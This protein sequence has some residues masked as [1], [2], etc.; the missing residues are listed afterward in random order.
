MPTIPS[1]TLLTEEQRQLFIP[2]YAKYLASQ[3]FS[4]SPEKQLPLIQVNQYKV[5]SSHDST[6]F[7]L[8]LLIPVNPQGLPVPKRLNKIKRA[9]RE[10]PISALQ[11]TQYIALSPYPHNRAN[12]FFVTDAETE[13]LTRPNFKRAN[14]NLFPLSLYKTDSELIS[15][16]QHELGHVM[17][18]HFYQKGPDSRWLE[19]IKNDAKRVS[20]YHDT[21]PSEDFAETF[22]FYLN[23]RGSF[24]K[25]LQ[26]FH[27]FQ[28]LD[29][30]F[31]TL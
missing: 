9:L 23:K 29:E 24:I 16:L 13:S 27:R 25:R 7:E 21:S 12:E 5:I 10:L 17:A 2:N 4:F 20:D 15:T 6:R 1:D 30:I 22:A 14:I 26:F 19:A 8:P 28:I 11:K 18:L 3:G 31:E